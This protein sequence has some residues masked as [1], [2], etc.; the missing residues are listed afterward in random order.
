MK[1]IISF[2]LVLL[3]ALAVTGFAVAKAK[4]SKSTNA[5]AATFTVTAT[6][7]R[8][9]R[10][11]TGADGTYNVTRGVYEG[12]AAGDPLLAGKVTVRTESVVNATSGLGWTKGHVAFRDADGKL[13]AKASLVAVNTG[14]TALN[15]FMTGRVKE[16]GHLLANFS[17]AFGADGSSLAGELGSGGA[18]N[19]AILTKGACARADEMHDDEKRMDGD[20]KKKSERD[21][22]KADHEKKKADEK[23]ADE[24][25]ADG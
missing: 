1:R 4:E 17:A 3:V 25:P 2:A 11:C 16:G 24:K 13:K 23:K 20:E 9:T 5:V 21:K 8:K 12:T 22:K 18:V 14:G 15:G 10:Q 7:D 19:S 6:A